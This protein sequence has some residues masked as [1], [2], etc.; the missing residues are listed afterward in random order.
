MP[1]LSLAHLG[2]NLKYNILKY[3]LKYGN[4]VVTSINNIRIEISS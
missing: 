1:S 4:L 2:Y 3:N